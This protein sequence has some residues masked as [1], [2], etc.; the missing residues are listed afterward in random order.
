[1]GEK[2]KEKTKN[3]SQLEVKLDR[4]IFT[5]RLI[6]E[7]AR[8]LQNL[9][10]ME[11]A[12]GYISLV[13]IEIGK[14]IESLYKN[15]LGVEVFNTENIIDILID[16]KKRIGG[17]FYIV[18]HTPEKIVLGSRQ[19][20]FEEDVKGCPSLCMM[21]ST[22][23]GGIVSRNLGYA[24][25]CLQASIAKKDSECRVVIYLQNTDEAQIAQGIEYFK[26]EEINL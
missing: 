20:P 8:V 16:L 18:S 3:L 26:E 4:D 25:V 14:M 19:C 13:G 21:T 5:R 22:V 24:K 1:M 6:K 17:D 11:Q 10:G 2:K 15:A 23:F 9:I 7:L 12:N